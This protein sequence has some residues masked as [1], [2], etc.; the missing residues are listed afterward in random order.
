MSR[1]LK[2]K[3][4]GK[5]RGDHIRKLEFT[6]SEHQMA[7][8]ALKI[9]LTTVQV[10][11]YTDFNREFILETD[12]SLKGLGAVYCPYKITPVKSML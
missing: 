4:E 8:D 3:K 10:L 6:N 9:A 5:E 7:F 11:G 12:A 2:V 1:R